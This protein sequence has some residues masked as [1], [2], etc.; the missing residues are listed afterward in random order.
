MSFNVL[1]GVRYT[2]RNMFS[3]GDNRFRI[4]FLDVR[5]EVFLSNITWSTFYLKTGFRNDYYNVNS[6]MAEQSFGDYD[7][8]Q[9]SNDYVT[10]FIDARKDSF[11]NAYIPTKGKSFG[12]SYDWVFGGG[13]QKFNNFHAL[14]LE[15]KQV[16]GGD[17]FAFIPSLNI[18]YLLGDEVPVPFTNT[19]GGSMVGDRQL[20][21]VLR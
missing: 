15:A 17:R 21:L 3:I 5:Q 11:D 8:N 20:C 18:R 14:T 9:L 2:D 7:V 6:L 4:N 19:I 16:V 1:A 13:P 10:F 12:L